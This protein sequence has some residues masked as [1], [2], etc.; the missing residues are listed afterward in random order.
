MVTLVQITRDTPNDDAFEED[1]R[2][3]VCSVSPAS[4]CQAASATDF[5][6]ARLHLPLRTRVHILNRG[7]FYRLLL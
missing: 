1:E 4:F 5:K 6:I 7:D 2:L 3:M